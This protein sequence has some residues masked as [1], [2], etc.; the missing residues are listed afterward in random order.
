MDTRACLQ[1]FEKSGI[2]LFLFGKGSQKIVS[3]HFALFRIIYYSFWLLSFFSQIKQL[4]V[5]FDIFYINIYKNMRNTRFFEETSN[6][7][8]CTNGPSM[9]KTKNKKHKGREKKYV[10]GFSGNILERKGN[11]LFLFL[12]LGW[13]IISPGSPHESHRCLKHLFAI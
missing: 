13:R 7:I 11:K 1:H 3:Y 6:K 2:S 10:G 5:I 12:F 9:Q 4:R 8:Q